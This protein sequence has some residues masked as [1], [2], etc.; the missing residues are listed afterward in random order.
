MNT[1]FNQFLF[2]TV[3]LKYQGHRMPATEPTKPQFAELV[4]L[5]KKGN[6]QLL[7]KALP[8]LKKQKICF[9][10]ADWRNSAELHVICCEIHLRRLTKINPTSAEAFTF[11]ARPL[12]QL[13]CFEAIKQFQ[14]DISNY[15]EASF[16]LGSQYMI[17]GKHQ[18]AI[19]HFVNVLIPNRMI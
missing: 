13:Q 15:F 5:Y 12:L 7:N 6:S 10:Q 8:L 14:R 18:L 1:V 3:R 2:L 16:S 4:G 19:D 11:W 17:E 9:R